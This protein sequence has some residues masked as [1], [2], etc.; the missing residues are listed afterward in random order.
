MIIETVDGNLLDLFDKRWF[1]VIVHGCNCY[2]T[3]GAGIAGQISDRFP[4]ALAADM[5]TT[6]GPKKLGT[7]SSTLISRD[8]VVYGHIV[9]MYTQDQPGPSSPEVLES[10]IRQGFSL[11]NQNRKDFSS[12]IPFIGIPMIGA[13]I[14]RGDWMRHVEIINEVTPDLDIVVINFKPY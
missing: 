7:Y 11:L 6:K 10:S 2:Q 9:N 14:A 3:M 5:K 12:T 1:N 13:G 4:E 8:N